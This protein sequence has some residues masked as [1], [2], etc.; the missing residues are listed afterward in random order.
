MPF[1]DYVCDDCGHSIVSRQSIENRKLPEMT[2]CTKCGGKITQRI[3]SAPG[4]ADPV[5]IGV[6]KQDTGFKEVLKGIH[7]K[8]HGSK[9]NTYL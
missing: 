2:P 5:R 3:L 6:T 1:Y 4:V 7:S 9:L 8:T